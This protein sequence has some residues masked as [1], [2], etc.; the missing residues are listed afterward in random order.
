MHDDLVESIASPTDASIENPFDKVN[1]E[2]PIYMAHVND[3]DPSIVPPK[4]D[5]TKEI[6]EL[7][8]RISNASDY[9]LKEIPLGCM[10][11]MILMLLR[12]KR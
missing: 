7:Q 9:I 2:R 1:S 8:L 3:E 4:N 12:G 6:L 10:R 5:L 11:D